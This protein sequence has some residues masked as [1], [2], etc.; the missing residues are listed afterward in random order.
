MD[1]RNLTEIHQVYDTDLEFANAAARVGYSASVAEVGRVAWQT[2][3][4]T[5]WFLADD[6]PLTWIE[7]TGIVNELA[8]TVTLEDAVTAAVTV[9]LTLSH[10]TSGTAAAGFGIGIDLQAET[11]TTADIDIGAIEFDWV[12]ATHA[13]RQS[14]LILYAYYIGNKVEVGVFVA[15]GSAPTAGNARGSGAV[16]LQSLRAAATDIASG[17]YSSL[18]GGSGNRASGDYSHSPGGKDGLAQSYGQRVQASGSFSAIGDAQSSVFVVR[19]SVDNS[20]ANWYELFLDGAA[21]RMAVPAD[22]V[23]TFDILIAGTTQGSTKSFGFRIEGV[24]EN[25]GGTTSVLASTVTTIYDTDD[26]DFD[27]RVSADDPNDALLVE[28]TDS[29]SGGDV[30]QWVA[31]VQTAEVT[32]I[33]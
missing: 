30:V 16:D 19:R 7:L 14:E 1:H 18:G 31:R 24:I 29:T 3:N 10:N 23:W 2:D 32:F 25:D 15:P 28:L 8:Q 6:S 9:L 11:S 12:V 21:E 17:D 20:D 4:N 5:I 27:A 33:T 26:T 22:T 13:S